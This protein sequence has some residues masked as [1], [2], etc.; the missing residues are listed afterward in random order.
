MKLKI[1]F[2][3]AS[4]MLA[5]QLFSSEVQ[6][7][8]NKGGSTV[9]NL[10][11]SVSFSKQLDEEYLYPMARDFADTVA[12][13]NTLGFPGGENLIGPFPSFT[14]GFSAG[15]SYLPLSKVLIQTE[16]GSQEL[17]KLGGALQVGIHFGMG[18]SEKYKTSLVGKV[19]G[20]TLST[21]DVL[22]PF[23]STLKESGVTN[24]SFSMFNIGLMLRQELIGVA[25]TRPWLFHFDGLSL[26]GGFSYSSNTVKMSQAQST[27][28]KFTSNTD[29][30]TTHWERTSD[31]RAET[32][33]LS[34]MGELRSGIRVLYALGFYAGAGFSLNRGSSEIAFDSIG[35]I[36]D[37]Q[38]G[39]KVDGTLDVKLKSFEKPTILTGYALGGIELNFYALRVAVDAAIHTTGVI[40]GQFMIRSAF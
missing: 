8:G 40:N 39:S 29:N 4:V 30:I 20:V 3:S 24:A 12:A 21:S 35:P 18:L 16:D 9:T 1:L 22:S 2:F 28:V 11:G 19:F 23:Q 32:G 36:K 13:S 37:D 6:Y 5:F 33:V 25:G 14:A 7:T 27:T 17:Q 38:G 15:T 10:Y 26:G 31:L 34:L